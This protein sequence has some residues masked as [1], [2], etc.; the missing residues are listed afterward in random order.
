MIIGLSMKEIK[1]I[2]IFDKLKNDEI[3]KTAAAKALGITKRWV[4]TKFKR[5]L[6]HGSAGIVHR[7][8]DKPSKR[9]WNKE[10]K[11]FAMSLFDGPFKGFGP[12]FASQKLSEIHGIKVHK[13]VLRTAMIKHGHWDGKKRKIKH[14]S[15][16]ERKG[17]YGEMVQLDGSPHDWF[18]GRGPKCT[19]INFVDDA[20]SKISFMALAEN[21]SCESVMKSFRRYIELNGVPKQLYV[22]YGSTFSVNTGNPNRDKITQFERACKELGV[23]IAYANSPQAKGRVERSHGTHQ[24]RLIKELR[25]AGISTIEQANEFILNT[26]LPSH[27]Q[28]FAV[29][30]AKQGDVHMPANIFNLDMIFCLKAER[31]LQNDF[32][33]LYK[34]RV[35]QLTGQQYAVVRPKE[36]ITI[37]ENFSGLLILYIRGIR[38]NYVELE[39]RPKKPEENFIVKDRVY[40]KPA[41]NHPWRRDWPLQRF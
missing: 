33:I 25:L 22:D 4:Q 30:A 9:A 27:N 15:Q 40:H 21:E 19:L 3:T 28:R 13:D 18:E 11:E 2:S 20:T 16:R 41:A 24:D 34:N 17:H 37:H 31:K 29:P 32:T 7:N 39:Q 1:Q 14:R 38:L 8:R 36:V 10:Q 12:T 5:Y 23:D 6:E 26:Y 35:L